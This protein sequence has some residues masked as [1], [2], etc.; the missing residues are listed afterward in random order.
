M[1]KQ[2]AGRDQLGGFADEFAKYNDD[3]LFGEVWSREDKLSLRDRSMITIAALMGKGILDSSL[4]YHIKNAKNNGLTQEEFVEIVTQLAFY[5]E[6]PNA[7]A[8]FKM[9]KEIYT[10][11]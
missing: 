1:V 11:E 4:A 3:L 10:D 6:W 9:G 8:V 5:T 2:T 7:W